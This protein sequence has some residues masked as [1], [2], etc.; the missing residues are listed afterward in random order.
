M[1]QSNASRPLI[2]YVDGPSVPFVQAFQELAGENLEKLYK[3]DVWDVV[4]VLCQSASL[5][6]SF[7]EESIEISEIINDEDFNL[8]PSKL[9]EKCLGTLER[10]PLNQ[11]NDLMIGIL[12][13]SKSHS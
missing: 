13:V 2:S 1:P 8:Y 4:T 6:E 11:V 9:C 5:A 10:F 7:S 12:S 3:C